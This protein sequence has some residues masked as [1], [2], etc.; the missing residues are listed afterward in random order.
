M[1][2]KLNVKNVAAAVG[3]GICFAIAGLARSLPPVGGYK[4]IPSDDSKAVEAAEFAIEEQGS[5]EEVS[6]ELGKIPS[7]ARQMVKAAN[8][9]LCLE[10][11]IDGAEFAQFSVVVYQSLENEFKLKSRSKQKCVE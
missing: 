9:K 11:G 4:I 5:K 6:I 1:K 10:A 2:N 3:L 8:Y 7:A